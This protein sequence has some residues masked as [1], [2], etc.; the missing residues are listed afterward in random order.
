MLVGIVPLKLHPQDQTHNWA[1]MFIHLLPTG[2]FKSK[3]AEMSTLRIL[4]ENPM[5]ANHPHVPKLQL[6]SAMSKFKGMFQGKDAISKLLEQLFGFFNKKEIKDMMYIPPASTAQKST[7]PQ[8]PIVE[9][10]RPE[11]YSA[12]RLWVV[13]RIS[14][15]AQSNYILEIQNCAA[16][17]IPLAQLKAFSSKPLAP[18]NLDSFVQY[19]SRSQ[20]NLPYVSGVVP[21][22]VSQDKTSRTHC[23]QRTIAR[24]GS[25]VHKFADKTNNEEV[26]TLIGFSK[27]N[28]ES[29]FTSGPSP[30]LNKAYSQLN[31]LLKCL[32]ASMD[33][34]R[35]SLENL[36]QRALAIV[37]SDERSDTAGDE[38]NFLRFR[39][40]Q[41]VS[42][43]LH[44]T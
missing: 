6:E 42:Y 18:I 35:K 12:Y 41:C 39:L 2:D 32:Y 4:S 34:D 24:I 17:N 11:S 9:L 40:G 15:Y 19:L 44:F 43:Q 36:M 31:S 37:T 16:V 22:D 1:R 3:S 30:S 38:C 33:F 20:C 13:P 21:F 23:S 28:I 29:L 7:E 14:D 26:P 10:R 27:E 5:I 25:D 8:Q